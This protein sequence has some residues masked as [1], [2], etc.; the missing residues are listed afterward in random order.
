MLAHVSRC[1]WC[2]ARLKAMQDDREDLTQGELEQL[3]RLRSATPMWCARLAASFGARRPGH[4]RWYAIAAVLAVAVGAAVSYRLRAD[5]TVGSLLAT[6]YTE[7]RP[8]EYRLADTGYGAV[9][10]QRRGAG[11]PLDRPASLLKAE[12]KLAGLEGSARHFWEWRGTAELLELSPEAA[13]Q[14]LSRAHEEYPEDT[15]IAISLAVA[16]DLRGDMRNRASDYAV[17]LDLLSKENRQH[18]GDTRVVFNLA[19]T[20]ERL[21]MYAE[22]A[23][24]WRRYLEVDR[25][26]KWAEE[27]RRHLREVTEH[28]R[29]R[30]QLRRQVAEDEKS[31]GAHADPKNADDYIERTVLEWLSR[32]PSADAERAVSRLDSLMRERH[33]DAW[34]ADALGE[35]EGGSSAAGLLAVANWNLGG[36]ADAALGAAD[37][38]IPK[39]RAAGAT[40]LALRAGL[41]KTYALHRATRPAECV[42]AATAVEPELERHSYRWMLIQARLERAVCANMLGQEG[43]SIRIFERQLRE[44]EECR[45]LTLKLRASGLLVDAR[46]LAGEAWAAWTDAL[47][48]LDE[49]WRSGVSPARAHQVFFNM[50]FAASRLELRS[51]A[52]ELA[53][54]AVEQIAATENYSTVSLGNAVAASLAAKAGLPDEAAALFD[55]AAAAQAKARPSATL[56]RYE[57]EAALC[58]VQFDLNRGCT[59]E[60]MRRLGLLDDRDG[61]DAF[62]VRL[63][64]DMLEGQAALQSADYLRA[65]RS[66]VSAMQATS[67]RLDSLSSPAERVRILDDANQCARAL[68]QTMLSEGQD[69]GHVLDVWLRLRSGPRESRSVGLGASEAT[70]VVFVV[71]GKRVAAWLV[72]RQGTVFRWL[73]PDAAEVE[74]DARVIAHLASD[75]ASSLD[76]LDRLSSHL[77]SK[78]LGPFEDRLRDDRPLMILSDG[79]LSQV[80]FGLLCTGRGDYLLDRHAIAQC[81]RFSRPAPTSNPR[82]T[83]VPALVV[84]QTQSSAFLSEALPPLPE[85]A[86]EA[87]SVAGRFGH[88]RLLEGSEVSRERIGSTAGASELFHFSGHGFANGGDGGLLLA[89]AV[90][91]ADQIGRMDWK[92]CR[93]AV[94]SA[95]LSAAGESRG[96]VN[97][98]SLV[99]A[100]LTAGAGSVV[101]AQWSIDSG[102]TRRWMDVFYDFY[103]ANGSAPLAARE[104]ARRVRAIPEFSHPYYWAA[105][106]VYE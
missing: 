22:A 45:F 100:F 26:S 41:E 56:R 102:A 79:G 78:L 49:Y 76:V 81:S 37:E 2:A 53:R 103:A 21:R 106:Q 31:F 24:Y 36:E 73:E 77:Y 69:P 82:A 18:P 28:A 68:M 89:N 72:D 94:L 29:V 12:A 105:F 91:S 6:A 16:Y 1:D 84:S 85:A 9:R 42:E 23:G 83:L 92:H 63:R 86:A 98:N 54:A 48:A 66:L 13:I 5:G 95:C 99:R 4:W 3:S 34:I 51:A 90:L 55:R 97:P 33:G 32:V 30:Q 14:S 50:A 40:A 15:Q 57:W 25:N 75:G 59:G 19:L 62:A 104:A 38:L 71:L 17:A 47:P 46:T 10:I 35:V 87:R 65:E 20:S 27:A 67:Q 11:S 52:L 61:P 64:R 7:S 96:P 43:G 101:A 74:R 88:A 70:W 44:A 80:P 93:L 39:L 8:F 58:R 60:A